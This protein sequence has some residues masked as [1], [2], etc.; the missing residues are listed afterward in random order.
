M[1]HPVYVMFEDVIDFMIAV[2]IAL[3][4]ILTVIIGE[5]LYVIAL[6]TL[7]S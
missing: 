4:F 2:T 6:G 7:H 3:F 1:I 5:H